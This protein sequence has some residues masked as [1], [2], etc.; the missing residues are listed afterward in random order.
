MVRK[1]EELCQEHGITFS[2]AGTATPVDSLHAILVSAHGQV[3]V[4][5]TR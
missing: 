2:A 3:V 1:S 5:L 4:V